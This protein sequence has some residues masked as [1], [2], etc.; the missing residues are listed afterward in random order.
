MND[1]TMQMVRMI[2]GKTVRTYTIT[3]GMPVATMWSRATGDVVMALDAAR[4]ESASLLGS[5]WSMLPSAL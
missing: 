4:E 1:A 3:K 2:S 5:G